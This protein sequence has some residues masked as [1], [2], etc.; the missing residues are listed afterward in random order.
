MGWYL[1]DLR[2]KMRMNGF[3]TDGIT[4][5]IVHTVVRLDADE[6]RCPRDELE[7]AI[8]D[9]AGFDGFDAVSVVEFMEGKL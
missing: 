6:I 7:R 2:K 9:A 1:N 8:V 3:G 5:A 4:G